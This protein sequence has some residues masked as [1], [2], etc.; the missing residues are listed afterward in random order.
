MNNYV[1]LSL[2]NKYTSGAN[3]FYASKAVFI[4][5]ALWVVWGLSC[6]AFT[7]GRRAALMFLITARAMRTFP[8]KRRE[9]Q[10]NPFPGPDVLDNGASPE[11]PSPYAARV[12]DESL[13]YL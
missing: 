10:A 2:F 3:Q 6:T 4:S 1:L 13:P 12:A 8:L 5:T 11:N 7:W 9:S